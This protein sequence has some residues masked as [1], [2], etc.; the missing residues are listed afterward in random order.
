M[1]NFIARALAEGATIADVRDFTCSI[2]PPTPRRFWEPGCFIHIPGNA[3]VMIQRIIA[4]GGHECQ[5]PFIVVEV[6]F[7]DGF[8]QVDRLFLSVLT[9]F[10]RLPDGKVLSAHGTA[11]DYIRSFLNWADALNAL[12]GRTLKVT[13][14]AVYEI[15]TPVGDGFRK[16]HIYGFDLVGEYKL[17]A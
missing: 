10:L 1:K 3:V 11:V 5:L 8:V 15:P 7:P 13:D 16:T 6:V 17:A 14:D 4:P 9:R 12:Q 2:I